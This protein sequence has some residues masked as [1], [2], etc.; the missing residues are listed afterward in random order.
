MYYMLD[1]PAYASLAM[2]SQSE[3]QIKGE[4]FVMQTTANVKISPISMI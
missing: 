3:A 1:N 4:G 2:H